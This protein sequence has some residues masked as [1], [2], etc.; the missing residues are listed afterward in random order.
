MNLQYETFP[1]QIAFFEE[2]A[3]DLLFGDEDY[4]GVSIYAIY[5]MMYEY[6]ILEDSSLNPSYVFKNEAIASFIVAAVDN[7]FDNE[8]L[9][10]SSTWFVVF[11]EMYHLYLSK[12]GEISESSFNAACA[13]VD[14]LKFVAS[15]NP[16][17][18]DI[19]KILIKYLLDI[20]AIETYKN[21]VKDFTYSYDYALTITKRDMDFNFIDEYLIHYFPLF[22]NAFTNQKE[23]D[24][25]LL[26]LLDAYLVSKIPQLLID[27]NMDENKDDNLID[28]FSYLLLG[29]LS[30]LGRDLLL[31]DIIITAIENVLLKHLI[32]KNLSTDYAMERYI[33]LYDYYFNN[34]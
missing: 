33:S 26:N 25:E 19:M 29:Y 30:I 11:A 5:L 27:D 15:I 3:T 13:I 31:D 1:A 12:I 23:M 2:S 6:Y 17:A 22:K 4:M 9:K 32:K 14:K 16:L 10:S 8:H 21:G 18:T 7:I 24:D 20:S 34:N 28:Y